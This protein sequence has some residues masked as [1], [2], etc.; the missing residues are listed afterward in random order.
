MGIVKTDY[1]IEQGFKYQGE[2]WWKWWVWIEAEPGLL[3]KIDYVLYTL[4]F[5]FNDPVR[6]MYN[7]NAKFRLDT[8]GWG[9]FTI[10]ARLYMKDGTEIPLEHELVL[11]YPDGK[12]NL[13]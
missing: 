7:R 13:S 8:E 11:E 10:Y 9:V 12:E 3:D 4:H 1:K 5:S 2:D 6:K